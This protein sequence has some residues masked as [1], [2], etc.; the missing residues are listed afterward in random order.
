MRV[1]L[2]RSREDIEAYASALGARVTAVALPLVGDEPLT[3]AEID[4]LVDAAATP[5]LTGLWLAS[6]RAVAPAVA[7][8]QTAGSTAP[9]AFTVGARTAAAAR[10]A[11]LSAESLGDD[12]VAAA[13]ALVRRGIGGARLLAPRSAD[14]RDDA[15]AVL[16]AAGATVIPAVAYR[17]GRLPSSHPALRAGLAALDGAAACL[18]FAPSQ[19]AALAAL[20]PLAGLPPLVAIGPTTAAAVADHGGRVA[21][22]AATPDPAGMA[23][24][25]A[26]VYPDAP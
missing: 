7:A 22:V 19:V 18:I 6:A 1:V 15:L 23:A 20:R 26:S 9:P 3:G 2:T 13:A 21:A 5:G 10:I 24:A 12:G 4:A 14:G 8:L 17:Q 16:T 11:G 25:L